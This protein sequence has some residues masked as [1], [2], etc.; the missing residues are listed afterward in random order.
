MGGRNEKKRKKKRFPLLTKKCTCI[1]ICNHMENKKMIFVFVMYWELKEL[2]FSRNNVIV[3][4][5]LDTA[6]K[7]TSKAQ[8]SYCGWRL[9]QFFELRCYQLAST[10]VIPKHKLEDIMWIW[11]WI[12]FSVCVLF[13]DN[14]IGKSDKRIAEVHLFEK[15]LQIWQLTN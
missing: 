3:H 2:Y 13:L 11:I 8:Q 15:L 7:V 4:Y 1:Y 5:Y 14:G 6:M 12:P 9:P 10:S